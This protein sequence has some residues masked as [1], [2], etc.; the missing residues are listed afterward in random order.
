MNVNDIR[1]YVVKGVRAVKCTIKRHPALF[2]FAA[3]VGAT[4]EGF[5]LALKKH[6]ERDREDEK[7]RRKDEMTDVA[8]SLNGAFR[9]VHL[10]CYVELI[11]NDEEQVIEVSLT[12]QKLEGQH[13]QGSGD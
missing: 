3:G 2:G 1:G 5:G 11:C 12:R 8:K 9:D 4:F 13:D 7:R 10:P 6:A